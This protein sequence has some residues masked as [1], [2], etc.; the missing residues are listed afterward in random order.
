MIT[1]AEINDKGRN[2]LVAYCREWLK[3]P[4][5]AESTASRLIENM[6]GSDPYERT[7]CVELRMFDTKTGNPLTYSFDESELTF[8]TL[9]KDGDE[10]LRE[11]TQ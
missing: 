10:V 5:D 6:D 9:N 4:R 11:A 1:F 8:I 7:I 2:N 3:D